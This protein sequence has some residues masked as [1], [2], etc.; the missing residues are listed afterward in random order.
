LLDAPVKPYIAVAGELTLR[1]RILPVTGVKAMVLA[2]HRAGLRALVLPARNER[3]LEEVPEEVKHDLEVHL[4]HHVDEVLPL[5][6]ATPEE[7][8]P[9]SDRSLPPPGSGEARP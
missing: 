6:L 8:G 2:A 1:G 7:R 4:V 3:D 5:V 9:L